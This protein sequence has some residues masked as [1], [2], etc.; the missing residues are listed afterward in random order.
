MLRSPTDDRTYLLA[1]VYEALKERIMDQKYPT[2]ERINIDAVA[3]DLGVSQ[4]PVREALARLSAERLVKMEPYKGYRVSPLLT[5]D[6]VIHLMHV[7]RLIEVD[8]ARLAAQ[9][10]RMPDL[11]ALER[12]CAQSGQMGG[13]SWSLG[14]KEFNTLDQRFHVSLLEMSGNPFLGSAFRSLNVHLEL[15]RFYVSFHMTDHQETCAEHL[16]II[17]ALRRRDA[18]GAAQA[19]EAHLHHTELRIFRLIE[20]A[21]HLAV[22]PATQVGIAEVTARRAARGG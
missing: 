4:T 1:T 16:L 9:R 12:I 22:A 17:E 2:D 8:A 21:Q 5:L 15:G 18:D 6:E 14:Y 13:S 11:L 19:T 3:A 20:E 10:A 7:R